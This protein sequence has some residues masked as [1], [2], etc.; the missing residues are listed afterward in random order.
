MFCLDRWLEK[1]FYLH[2][3]IYLD[4]NSGWTQRIHQRCPYQELM[5]HSGEINLVLQTMRV[6]L[7]AQLPIQANYEVLSLMVPV[8]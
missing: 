1:S 6:L 4:A 5:S 2:L 8:I 3:R 7:Q